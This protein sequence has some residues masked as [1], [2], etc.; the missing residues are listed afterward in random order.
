[1]LSSFYEFWIR[2]RESLKLVT[3]FNLAWRKEKRE[4]RGEETEAETGGAP[5]RAGKQDLKTCIC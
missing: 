2:V 3:L 1:M 5:E 4:E